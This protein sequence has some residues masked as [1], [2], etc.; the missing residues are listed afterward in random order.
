MPFSRILIFTNLQ[1]RY[2]Y[3][4][5]TKVLAFTQSMSILSLPELKEICII[6]KLPNK[7]K[8][9]IPRTWS[10]VTLYSNAIRQEREQGLADFTEEDVLNFSHFS[11][12]IY[13]R[14]D[15]KMN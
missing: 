4:A 13:K 10:S 11:G 14:N 1:V 5:R 15:I 6:S 8:P 9:F 12:K 7:A 2:S 3:A